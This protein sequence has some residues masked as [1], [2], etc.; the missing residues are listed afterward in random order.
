MDGIVCDKH[1]VQRQRPCPSCEIEKR[2]TQIWQLQDKIKELEADA[3]AHNVS[4]LILVEG[5]KAYETENK[6]LTEELDKMVTDDIA[7]RDIIRDMEARLEMLSKPTGG[8]PCQ[9]GQ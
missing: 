8:E 2:D 1:G 9:A 5:G 3:E 7:H 4:R 6:R